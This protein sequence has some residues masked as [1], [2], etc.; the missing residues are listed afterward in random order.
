[1][2]SSRR[3]IVFLDILFRMVITL[4]ETVR[5]VWLKGYTKEV[6]ACLQCCRIEEG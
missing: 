2:L 4:M 5:A 6:D 3:S 1:M